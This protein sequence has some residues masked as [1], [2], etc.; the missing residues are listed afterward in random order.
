MLNVPELKLT[1]QNK[2]FYTYIN[3]PH[4]QALATWIT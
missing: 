2:I 1:D 3:A 4:P